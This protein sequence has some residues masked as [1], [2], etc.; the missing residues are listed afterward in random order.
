[1]SLRQTLQTALSPR[2]ARALAYLL[3]L[4]GAPL[5]VAALF[6]WVLYIPVIALWF[7]SVP[8]LALAGPGFALALRRLPP[9][10][11]IFAVLGAALNLASPLFFAA[12]LL[13]RGESPDWAVIQPFWTFGFGMAALWGAFFALLYR[14]TRWLL[15]AR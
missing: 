2:A 8:Y 14:A 13:S 6:F 12:F 11:L 4:I 7:G 9:N 3:A 10:P 1:M 5:V 15:V